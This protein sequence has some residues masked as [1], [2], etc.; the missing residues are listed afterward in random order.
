[1]PDF[2]TFPGPHVRGDGGSRRL[3][4]ASNALVLRLS[5]GAHCVGTDVGTFLPH[6]DQ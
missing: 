2:T 1:M 6:A 5:A 4:V 3:W